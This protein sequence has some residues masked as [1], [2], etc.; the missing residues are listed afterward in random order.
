M[1]HKCGNRKTSEVTCE[2]CGSWKLTPLGIGTQSVEKELIANH[3]DIKVFRLDS[4]A[5]S[6][7][8]KAR[9]IIHEFLHTPGS[10]LIG[11]EMA[12]G[13]LGVTV[14]NVAVASVD[15]LFALPDFRGNERIFN[16]LL[17]LYTTATKN[18]VI[19]TRS[20]DT[21]LFDYI[22]KGNLLDFYR[23]E[24]DERKDLGYPPYKTFVKI[25]RE[26]KKEAVQ[27]DMRKLSKRL[28]S[29][30]ALAFPAFIQEIKNKYRMHILIK[31]DRS[32]W[33]DSE[34]LDIL[35]SLSPSFSI[36]IDPENLM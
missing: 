3:S 31:L 30:E 27:E 10:I 12:L 6:T 24:I 15:S 18:F 4:D 14:E 25:T 20:P 16:L 29:Y 36:N 34:L 19:Q 11:T 26:G 17:R 9:T 2:H 28:E 7:H 22:T 8:N 5:A 21:P 32:A 13:Y 33:I 23:D 1:C 35:R